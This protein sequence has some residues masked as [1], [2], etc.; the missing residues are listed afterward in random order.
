PP[1]RPRGRRAAGDGAVVE[2]SV[3]GA[4]EVLMCGQP[5]V[6]GLRWW[7]GGAGRSRC[8]PSPSAVL[9][10][11]GLLG[12]VERARDLLPRVAL[13][14]GVPDQLGLASLDR[15]ELVP[16]LLGQLDE[17]SDHLGGPLAAASLTHCC[18]GHVVNVG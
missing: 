13:L 9:L 4:V 17:L 5:F 11:H 18:P 7:A 16:S 1:K 12:D 15:R 8:R 6:R 14:A 3:C 10:V 2:V